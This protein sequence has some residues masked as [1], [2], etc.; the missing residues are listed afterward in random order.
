MVAGGF[1]RYALIVEM[2]LIQ[3]YAVFVLNFHMSKLAMEFQYKLRALL[4]AIPNILHTVLSLALV[5]CLQDTDAATSKILGNV[6]G[7][8]V[9]ASI[10][11]ISVF[12]KGRILIDKKYWR[13]GLAI[14]LPSI[15]Y[16]LSDLL[17]MQCDRIMITKFV[18]AAATGI[19]SNAYNIGIILWMIS[20]ATG[21]A[22]LPWFYRK[23]NDNSIH[24]IQL[25][26]KG[27][28]AVFSLGAACLL[29]VSPEI[30]KLLTPP[31]YWEGTMYLAPII[32][33][34]YIMFLYSFPV[35]VEFYHKK[36]GLIARNTGVASGLNIALNFIFIPVCGP[37]AAALTTVVSYGLLFF[38]QWRSCKKLTPGLFDTRFFLLSATAIGACSIFLHFTQNFLLARY[39]VFTLFVVAT[40][41][42]VVRNRTAIKSVLS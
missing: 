9:F 19:Y 28:L 35:N 21:S 24:E 1:F 17:L 37:G 42:F 30:L 4:L 14:S 38:L 31:A 11:Y 8:A 3:S 32:F 36:T 33:S 6:I 10:C 5:Y 7:L 15:A 23:L 25:Y 12:K 39:S 29:M 2:A 20:T 26:V 40:V 41:I 27:Y 18:S 16:S 34:A 13:Y 22:W